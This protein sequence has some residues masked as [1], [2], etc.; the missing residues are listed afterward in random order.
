MSSSSRSDQPAYPKNISNDIVKKGYATNQAYY[1]FKDEDSEINSINGSQKSSKV[2]AKKVSKQSQFGQKS[3]HKPK[4]I[5]VSKS[6][7][8]NESDIK[9]NK[10]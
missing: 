1:Q 3:Q 10:I 7:S 4:A 2:K 5:K 8:N 6:S 9:P